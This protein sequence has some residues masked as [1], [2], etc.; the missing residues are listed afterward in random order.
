[1]EPSTNSTNL[2]SDVIRKTA[3]ADAWD[4]AL[5][6]MPPLALLDAT[7]G[8]LNRAM[9]ESIDK[10]IAAGVLDHGQLI[11]AALDRIPRLRSPNGHKQQLPSD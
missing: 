10:A 3:L 7:G 5:L 6:M 11:E 2:A 1:M 4:R 9:A 8:S